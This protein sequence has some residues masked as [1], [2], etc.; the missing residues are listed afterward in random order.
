MT[1]MA[2]ISPNRPIIMKLPMPVR[3]RLVTVAVDVI[4]P[5]MAAQVT[6]VDMTEAP[7]YTSSTEDRNAPISAL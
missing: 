6:N 3:S 7:V 1:I 5:N 4:P 2:M